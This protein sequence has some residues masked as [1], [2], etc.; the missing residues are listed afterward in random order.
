M[1]GSMVAGTTVG[2]IATVEEE[3]ERYM[4]SHEIHGRDD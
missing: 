2:A 4:V 3:L 1:A